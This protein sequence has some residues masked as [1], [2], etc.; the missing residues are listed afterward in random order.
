MSGA[1]ETNA[2]API[3]DLTADHA[4]ATLLERL[5][6]RLGGRASAT[7]VYGQPV[8]RDGSNQVRT[9]LRDSKPRR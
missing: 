5:A 2:P 8:T 4:C 1:D 9:V 6:D 7:A 3:R